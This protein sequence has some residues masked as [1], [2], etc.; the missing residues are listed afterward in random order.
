MNLREAEIFWNRMQLTTFSGYIDDVAALETPTESLRRESIAKHLEDLANEWFVGEDTS[1][2]KTRLLTFG[3]SILGVVTNESDLDTVLILP[4]TI[5]REK[6]FHN[7]VEF[8]KSPREG[9]VI[10]SIMA[11]P[12]AHVPVLKMVV[13]GLPVDILTCRIPQRD[14][15]AFIES[16]SRNG[17][18]LD[19]SLIHYRE[20]DTASLL[21]INGVRVGRTLVDSIRAGR[22]I[23]EDESVSGGND[24][25]VKFQQCLRV[26]K[27]WAKQRGVYS[28]VMGF[29]GGVSWAILLV[30][31]CLSR[32][33]HSVVIDSE[34]ASR[35]ICRFFKMWHEWQWG[36][37][38]PVSLRSLPGALTQYLS[39]LRVSAFGTPT[40]SSL[41]SPNTEE[42][43]LSEKTSSDDQLAGVTMWD[44][45]A[46]EADRKSLMPVLTPVA[47]FMNSTFN[48][49]P[50]TFRILTD[51][52]RRASEICIRAGEIDPPQ[53]QTSICTN[54]PHIPLDRLCAS[55]FEE[56]EKW[57]PV[58]LP[59]RLSVLDEAGSACQR[60]LFVWESLIESKLRVLIFHLEKLPGVICRPF[61]HSVRLGDSSTQFLIGISLLPVN[62]S[63]ARL[64][65]FNYA[66]GQF[67]GAVSATLQTR[68]DREELTRWCRL[69]IGLK[70]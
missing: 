32:T 49:L 64:L 10:E 3:S 43:P 36:V 58:I 20:L 69:E 5:S 18:Q 27:Y 62:H 52:F 15:R 9:F 67:H 33:E 8:L 4:A 12:D 38:N 26:V 50:T 29:F 66:V 17:G 6:F 56:L 40:F 48:T 51:E 28:N 13:N 54:P 46:S 42:D 65:D 41:P 53:A 44:P 14:Y 21:S 34:D 2:S 25:L 37:A 45:L 30:V 55:S 23:A 16:P 24:R 39:S 60:L 22:L 35:I 1:G 19:F 61:P 47:P 59:L 7:F 11:V 63:D 31:T 70:K 57:Y 68:P